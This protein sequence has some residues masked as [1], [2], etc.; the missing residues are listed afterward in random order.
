[1]SELIPSDAVKAIQDGVAV[2]FFEIDGQTYTSKQVFIPPADPTPATLRVYTLA[3]V[4]DFV[5]DF[6]QG[7]IDCIHVESPTKVQIYGPL[8]GRH[9]QRP[10]YLTAAFN[11]PAFSF[12]KYHDQEDFIIGVQAC[13]V[14]TDQRAALLALVGNLTDEAVR[15][16][17]DDGVTQTVA[18]RRGIS[19]AA[20]AS[21]PNPVRLNPYRTFPEIAQP[22]SDFILRVRAGCEVAL[23]K[24]AD[25][26]WCL[27]A[28]QDIA[29]FLGER[30]PKTTIL[31]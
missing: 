17:S 1:M 19:M 30:L 8:E 26:A 2:E 25:T 29:A 16:L 3:A 11:A 12:D 13:F 31:A 5:K 10:C 18:V 24:T 28:I 22:T 15:N 27:A 4:T 7:E 20:P 6:N 23:F 14:P 9:K 21:V